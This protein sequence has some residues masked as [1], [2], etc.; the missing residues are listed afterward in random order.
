[1][2]EIVQARQLLLQAMQT[3]GP[4]F[5]YAETGFE[6]CYYTLVPSVA[7]SRAIT[8][9]LIGVALDLAGETRHKDFYGNVVVLAQE[10]PDMMSQA[11]V[12]Y[13]SVAQQAQDKGAAW[14]EAYRLA[15]E[16]EKAQELIKENVT[17]QR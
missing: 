9:C 10:F 3:Q 11:T 13:F 2:I 4:D 16:E 17:P 1:M 12:L 14:G 15:E 8:G 7:G 6:T 5:V